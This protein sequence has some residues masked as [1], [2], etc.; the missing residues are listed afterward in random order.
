MS[1]TMLAGFPTSPINPHLGISPSG[2]VLPGAALL[3]CDDVAAEGSFLLLHLLKSHLLSPPPQGGGV[4]ERRGES[5]GEGGC[6]GGGEGCVRTVCLVALAHPPS[7]YSHVARRMS[8]HNSPH[9]ANANPLRA[10]YSSICAAVSSIGCPLHPSQPAHTPSHHTQP[11]SNPAEPPSHTTSHATSQPAAAA[12]AAAGSGA[13]AATSPSPSGAADVAPPARC[14]G[15]LCVVI[16]DVSLLETCAGGDSRLLMDFLSACRGLCTKHHRTALVLLTHSAV[17]PTTFTFAATPP[18]PLPTL[19]SSSSS[20]PPLLPWLLHFSDVLVLLRPL[21][22]GHASDVHGQAMH[23]TSMEGKSLR[24]HLILPPLATP[25]FLTWLLHLPDVLVLLRPLTSGHASDVHGQV[26]SLRSSFSPSPIAS[27]PLLLWLLHFSDVLVLL[28][29]LTTGHASDVHGLTAS[30]PMGRLTGGGRYVKGVTL[31]KGTFGVVFKAYD[32]HTGKTVAIKKI[33]LGDCKEGVNVTALR[34]IKLLQELH[35]PHIIDLIDIYPHK[36]NLNLVLEFMETD[37]ENII[38]DCSLY[39]SPADIKAFMRM[40][41][42]GL[43]YLHGKWVLHRDMKPNNLLIGPTGELKIA[44]FG[45]ARLFGSPDRKLTHQVFALW[46]QGPPFPAPSSPPDPSLPN[47]SHPFP[48]NPTVPH[49]FPIY[50]SRDMKPNNLLIGP[51]GE[52][53]IADFGFARLFGSPDRK[54]THQVFALWYRAPELLFGSKAYGSGVDVWGAGCV[55]AELLLRRPFLQGSSDIDQLGKIFAAL[56]TPREDQ[57]PD[58]QC[59]PD[60]VHF[61]FCPAPPL[62]SHFPMAGDDALDLLSR[63]LTF[64]PNK[65]ITAAQALQH[66]YFLL[67]PP[68]TKPKDLPRPPPK[69]SASDFPPG[70]IPVGLAPLAPDAAAAALDAANGAAAGAGGDAKREGTAGSVLPPRPKLNRDDRLALRK[71]AVHLPAAVT[72][73]FVIPSLA[74]IFGHSL[75]GSREALST[76][77]REDTNVRAIRYKMRALM[78]VNEEPPHAGA[79]H[80]MA[81]DAML[82][83][84]RG[85][86]ADADVAAENTRRMLKREKEERKDEGHDWR[87]EENKR[88][89]EENKRKD[90]ENKRKDEENK[91]KDEENRRKDE[92][93]KRKDEENRTKDEENRRKA[94]ENGRKDEESKRKDEEN[95]R[96]DEENKRKDEENKRKDEE[97][98]RKDEENKRKDEENKRKDEENKRKDEENKRKDEENKRKDEEN[99]RKDEENKR[100]DEE[101]KRKD[102]ENKR[103]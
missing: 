101:N 83:A 17:H 103:N 11:P 86:G 94:E 60:Y 85:E 8:P 77:V 73:D 61:N 91:R 72:A 78:E 31:G 25:S 75:L 43:A 79:V 74:S 84:L 62:K 23:Q 14:G 44:D 13:G 29:P 54:L 22:S 2:S 12:A 70:S 47:P 99:K 16:D 30:V 90:E 51:T 89:D 38:K 52:L 15:Q 28:R 6:R 18:P 76:D 68:A 39:L 20:S 7:H 19:L 40:T 36:R 96:K 10:L 81:A 50:P 88:K 33:H 93:N 87:D 71:L 97:N 24:P 95:K 9:C 21:T 3:L 57:W 49:T 59:L 41:L 42:E 58:M 55:F 35:H 98:K 5:Q 26:R 63:M 53:K 46:Y 67:G 1:V 66:R 37:L 27:P 48:P 4:G 32:T 92:E 34:E 82:S 65:R 45:F 56:G 80:D 100:K 69:P 102:E 64:D